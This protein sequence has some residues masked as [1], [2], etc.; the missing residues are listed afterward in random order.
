MKH[1]HLLMSFHFFFCCFCIVNWLAHSE[2]TF[3]LLKWTL[4]KWSNEY[5]FIQTVKKKL[6]TYGSSCVIDVIWLDSMKKTSRCER[7]NL[8]I[9]FS[10]LFYYV[11]ECNAFEERE[12]KKGKNSEKKWTSERENNT[13]NKCRK[14][15]FSI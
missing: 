14:S 5:S 12:W 1:T 10:F 13:V 7:Q 9:D 4:K 11:N 2:Y 6:F 8:N 3:H 15:F